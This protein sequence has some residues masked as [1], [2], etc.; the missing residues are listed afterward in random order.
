MTAGRLSARLSGAFPPRFTTGTV[1]SA[2]KASGEVV[3]SAGS[4]LFLALRQMGTQVDSYSEQCSVAVHISLWSRSVAPPTRL[5][6]RTK[7]SNM[8]ASH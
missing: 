3:G 5:E 6:T 8:Y 1:R 4:P 7:E 2:P